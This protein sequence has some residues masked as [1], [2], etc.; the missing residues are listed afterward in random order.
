M[1]A[2][3]AENNPAYKQAAHKSLS[4]ALQ[5]LS[6]VGQSEIAR[7]LGIS[8]ATVSRIKSERLEEVVNVLAACGLKV[9]PQEFQGD[10]AEFLDAALVFACYGI[11]AVRKDQRLLSD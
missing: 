10:H 11:K 9:V 8:D 5:A 6:S 1:D 7:N 4:L 3:V 2:K